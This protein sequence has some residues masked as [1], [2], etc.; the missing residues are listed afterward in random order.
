MFCNSFCNHTVGN[1]LTKACNQGTME[2][3]RML[4]IREKGLMK[5]TGLMLLNCHGLKKKIK[6]SLS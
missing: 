2:I 5:T 4:E 1:C 3:C 6:G